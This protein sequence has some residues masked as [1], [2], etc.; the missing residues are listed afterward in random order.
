MTKKKL[1]L[2]LHIIN[3]NGNIKRLLH[4]G[5]TFRDIAELTNSAIDNGY[6][7]YRDQNVALTLE[8]IDFLTAE[9][10]IL[11]KVDKDQWIK[12]ELSSEI[13]KLDKNVIFLPRQNELTF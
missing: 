10:Q 6:L 13:Q 4:E 11:K 9:Q 2:L 3:S 12:K 7:I 5:L 8:G 1:V